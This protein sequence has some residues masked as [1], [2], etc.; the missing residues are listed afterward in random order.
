MKKIW[1]TTDGR[2]HDSVLGIFTTEA[3][4]RRY[5]ELLVERYAL[6]K[7]L[8]LAGKPL[9]LD[10]DAWRLGMGPDV[11]ERTIDG[12]LEFLRG[13]W[14]V[15]VD[16]SCRMIACE[17]STK[18]KPNHP[19]TTYRV[20]IHRVCQAH[21]ATPQGALDAARKGMVAHLGRCR[22]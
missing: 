11:V 22:T 16:E 4:A 18:L 14:I 8:S 9:A 6:G 12:N 1:L 2:P 15:K 7:N 20:G 19:P 17:F 13:A 10:A 5:R 21:G 3:G